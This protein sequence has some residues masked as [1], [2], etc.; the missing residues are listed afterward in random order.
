MSGY[1][2][3]QPVPQ[4]TQTRDS[5]TCTAGQ[6]SFATSGYTPNFLDVYLN[7]VKLTATDYTASNGSDVVLAS[8]AATGDVLEVVAYT[9]F[10]AANVTGADDFTVTGSFTSQGI[11]DNATSTA[12]T[13]DGSG[14]LL[15]GKTSADSGATAGIE[16]N[17]NGRLNA[18]RNGSIAG[19]FNR[20]T[21]DGDILQFRKDGGVV[22]SIGVNSSRPYFE[23]DA[24]G[25]I[26][27]SSSGGN[28]IVL[29]TSGAGAL[30]DNLANIGAA[31]Y[32][33]KDLYLSGGVFLGG[34]GSANKLDDYEEGTWTPSYDCVTTSPTITY[35]SGERSAS[36]I[37]IG[38]MVFVQ[39]T[40]KT[41]A[42][43]GG[44]GS[45]ML[46]GLPFS[47][48]ASGTERC[49]GFSVSGYQT[50][51]GTSHPTGGYI[52]NGNDFFY[53]MSNS[54][55][56]SVVALDHTDLGAGLNNNFMMFHGQYEID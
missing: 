25:G 47:A 4:A 2:G 56:A 12:M 36:Y 48:K 13:L 18:T 38:K 54:N 50:G 14:N 51:F 55:T 29:P 6:T 19:V 9:A 41:D 44:N 8:G 40:L 32:R 26:T 35:D 49:G 43:S 52:N 22:A 3:T 30:S 10:E 31:A 53:I 28:P 21:S 42:V 24:A 46:T 1:I 45:L 27:I 5:F 33:F 23:K 20:L 39:G 34:V 17:D 37:K 11:D 7:G 15:V 16:T